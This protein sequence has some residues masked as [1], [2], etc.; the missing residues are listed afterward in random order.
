MKVAHFSVFGPRQCGLYHT[1]K[2]LVL[3]ERSVGIDARF[4][5]VDEEGKV[6]VHRDGSFETEKLQWAYGADILV[7]HSAIPTHVQNSGKPI[8]MCLHGRPESS[9]RLEQQKTNEVISAAANKAHD[10]RYKAFVTF[11]PEY[12]DVWRNIVGEKIVY[13]PACV[14]LREW[15]VTPRPGVPNILIADIWR[16][17]I[18]PFNC[19]LA[20]QRFCRL[21]PEARL[22]ILAMPKEVVTPMQHILKD[23]KSLVEVRGQT[24]D[25]QK[26]YALADMVVTPHLIATRIV[27]ESMA[28]D[29]P[30][31]GG[32]GSIY[33]PFTANPNDVEGIVRAMEN[34]W[35]ER[36]HTRNMAEAMFGLPATGR[37]MRGLFENVL[38]ARAKSTKRKVFVDIGA[39]LGEMVRRFYREKP[40]A[41]EYEIYCFEPDRETF[42]EGRTGRVLPRKSQSERR[43]HHA[44]GQADGRC[45]LLQTRNSRVSGLHTLAQIKLR[46][47]HNRQNEYRRGRI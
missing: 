31:V 30:V 19:V 10:C 37:S 34:C 22:Y 36:P 25:M 4:V 17:D 29:V 16:E 15:Q 6:S 5:A 26:Y 11:W 7:R 13:V 41:H 21:H 35:K 14:N 33:T 12:V 3:A 9:L 43:W 40:D 20:A 46:R 1:A 28:C 39:H 44:E 8:I 18:T 32:D 42:T 45:G 38:Y 47:L 23:C 2:D 24:K 27:R